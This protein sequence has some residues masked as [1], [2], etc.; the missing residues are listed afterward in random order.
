[1]AV[2]ADFDFY[3]GT[4][5]GSAIA[6]AD[7]PRLALRAS[8]F[9]DRLTFQRAAAVVEDDT[10][11]KLINAV[12]MAT[13]AVAEEI[14]KNEQRE[15]GETGVIASE[16]QGQYAVTYVELDDARLSADARIRKATRLY[17]A[18]TPLMF[19]GFNENERSSYDL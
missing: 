13:C 19:A 7:F 1:M 10:D 14:Q 3:S 12:Q 9:I 6:E 4:Y 5:L 15:A 18:H 16:K 8:M 17:F 11:L 2:Y